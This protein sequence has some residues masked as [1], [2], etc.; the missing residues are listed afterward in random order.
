MNSPPENDVFQRPR[1]KPLMNQG[2]ER[3]VTTLLL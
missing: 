3:L 2:G 1:S